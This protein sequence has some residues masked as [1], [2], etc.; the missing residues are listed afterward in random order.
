MKGSQV[1]FYLLVA[2]SLV[3][4]ILLVLRY[5]QNCTETTEGFGPWYDTQNR[6]T[7]AQR[8]LYQKRFNRSLMTNTGLSQDMSMVNGAIHST[9]TYLNNNTIQEVIPAPSPM[10]DPY[11]EFMERDRRECK[12]VKQPKFYPAHTTNP[13]TSC[14]WWYRDDPNVESVGALGTNNGPID[15]EIAQKFPGGTWEWDLAKAQKLEDAKKCRRIRNCETANFFPD[16][17]G[18]CVSTNKGIPTI[19]GKAKYPDDPDLGCER[20]I[21]NPVNCPRPEPIPATVIVTEA[22]VVLKP[23]D[24]APDGTIVPKVLPPQPPPPNV[25]DPDPTTGQLTIPCLVMIATTIG[26]STNGVLVSILQ[27]DKLGYYFALGPNNDIMRIVLRIYKNEAKY[28]LLPAIFGDGTISKE[29]VTVIYSKIMELTNSNKARVRNASRWLVYGT[30]F[31]PCEYDADQ[32]GPF[33]EICL[34]RVA[35]E[36]GCQ[37]D[38]YRFPN[39][40]NFMDYF[41]MSWGKY[42]A[43]WKELY[44][45]MNN[46]NTKIQTNATLDCLGITVA[47]EKQMDCSAASNNVVAS[48]GSIESMVMSNP[49]VQAAEARIDVRKIEERSAKSPVEK[50]QAKERMNI[51]LSDKKIITEVVRNA[52]TNQN[53]PRLELKDVPIKLKNGVEVLWYSW[54]FEWDFPDRAASRMGFYGREF[55]AD[56][57]N[58]NTGGNDFNPFKLHDRVSMHIRTNLRVPTATTKRIWAI[59][60]DGLVIKADNSDLIRKFWDQ[61]PTG[62]ESGDIKMNADIPK[63][64]DFFWFENGGGATFMAKMRDTTKIEN[65]KELPRIEL[66]VTIPLEFPL[67]RWDLYNGTFDERGGILTANPANVSFATM[68]GKK[69]A[70]LNSNGSGFV[71]VNR[72]RGSAFNSFSFMTYFRGATKWT[73]LFS[74]RDGPCVGNGFTGWAIEGG[75]CADGKLWFMM[76]QAGV[77]LPDLWATTSAGMTPVNKW[78]HIAFVLDADYKGVSIFLNGKPLRKLRNERMNGEAYRSR[79]YVNNSIGHAN[80][81]CNGPATPPPDPQAPVPYPPPTGLKYLGCWGDDGGRPLPNRL[82]NVQSVQTCADQAKKAGFKRFG[83]QYY[84]ECWAGNNSDWNRAGRRDGCPPLGGGWNNQVYEFGPTLPPDCPPGKDG[85]INMG[86]AWVHWFDY[87]LSEKDVQRDMLNGFTHPKLLVEDKKAGWENK[88]KR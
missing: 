46:S 11:P 18:F 1:L 85:S 72:I 68:D 16:S 35:L 58:F 6:F 66:F 37:R 22:G 39:P 31:D 49:A 12:P 42:N 27:D 34:E 74:L 36:I 19:Q 32:V 28:P 64:L 25:C 79:M 59:T 48:K 4:V 62:Y 87:S 78:T 65:Y 50:R 41:A 24:K 5:A 63:R 45:S 29:D 40:N 2:A 75:I 30:D 54:D 81:G 60:D 80:W 51:A 8:D 23:G 61:G 77:E 14:S 82:P 55:K 88:M 83:V 33:D 71:V 86:L 7:L 70:Q 44:N 17:C 26:Y 43:F 73:R 47:V 3:F 76:R 53:K 38:G 67:A 13:P 9:D 84:G 52:L 56:L 20:V 21:T 15:R 57:P 69:C 10:D